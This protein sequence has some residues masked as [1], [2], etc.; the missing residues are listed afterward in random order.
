MVQNGAWGRYLPHLWPLKYFAPRY[1]DER[2]DRSG[3]IQNEADQVPV[4]IATGREMVLIRAEAALLRGDWNG[5]MDLINQVHTTAF[6]AGTGKFG[7]YFTGEAL[8]PVVATNLDE[9]WAALK[10]ERF[11]EM[12]L[13]GR[14]LGDRRRWR[15]T[16]TPGE[17]NPLEYIPDNHGSASACPRTRRSASR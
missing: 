11:I 4:N 17:I 14:R 7:S 12:S 10:F 5:A 2:T 15:E 6:D 3:M 1:A 16:Q 13:E 9:A 8:E